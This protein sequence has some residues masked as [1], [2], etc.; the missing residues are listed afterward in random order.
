MFCYVISGFQIH[1][2]NFNL[3]YFQHDEAPPHYATCIL[4]YVDE[5]FKEKWLDVEGQ[6]YHQD[7]LTLHQW[8]SFLWGFV[9]DKV[10]AA[11]PQAQ[12]IEELK[13]ATYLKCSRRNR[14]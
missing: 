13:E 9:K 5:V 2:A 8:I 7:L 12:T 10:Y 3:L 14:F 6:E 11:K 1:F 4:N